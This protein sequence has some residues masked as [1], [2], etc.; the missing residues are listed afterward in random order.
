MADSIDTTYS[1]INVIDERRQDA[2]ERQ[3]ASDFSSTL[4]N[5]D[6]RESYVAEVTKYCS[7]TLFDQYTAK[8]KY[9]VYA[10]EHG[11]TYFVKFKL[12]NKDMDSIDSNSLETERQP[13]SERLSHRC[14]W[15]IPD[16]E[17]TRVVTIHREGSLTYATCSCHFHSRNR[18]CCRHKYAVFRKPP[19]KTDSDVRW[20]LAYALYYHRDGNITKQLEE[21][22]ENQPYGVPIEDPSD[23]GQFEEADDIPLDFFSRSLPGKL[24]MV[25]RNY[26]IENLFAAYR[27]DVGY[28]M[29]PAGQDGLQLPPAGLVAETHLSQAAELS[30][31]MQEQAS[32]R[33]DEDDDDPFGDD[34][35]NNNV[36]V[37]DHESSDNDG[38]VTNAFNDETR[39]SERSNPYTMYLPLYSEVTKCIET[40]GEAKKFTAM[41][42]DFHKELLQNQVKRRGIKAPAG[43][44]MASMSQVD[45][46][47]SNYR[48]RNPISS[49]KKSKSKSS[50]GQQQK[51][52]SPAKKKTRMQDTTMADGIL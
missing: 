28:G 26:W 18:M 17:H 12:Y 2:K 19:T 21:I 41:L 36:L 35:D 7:Q 14:S 9:Y 34:D 42:H 38:A 33:D 20:W 10:A 48:L 46:S 1:K 37:E 16:Y 15:Y 11:K 13:E 50:R 6:F 3:L 39:Y 27:P 24:C 31:A 45:T 22:R 29:G 4:V 47:R 23:I 5:P 8:D 44:G 43:G 25:G 32:L 30:Q 49:P 51:G 40:Q 52:E